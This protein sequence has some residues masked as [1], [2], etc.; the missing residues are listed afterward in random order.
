MRA[1]VSEWG[2]SECGSSCHISPYI[3]IC[4]SRD[5]L[6][7]VPRRTCRDTRAKWRFENS[8]VKCRCRSF[9]TTYHVI[10]PSLIMLFWLNANMLRYTAASRSAVRRKCEHLIDTHFSARQRSYGNITS[11][12]S[13]ARS[14]GMFFF[15]GW[16]HWQHSQGRRGVLGSQPGDSKNEAVDISCVDPYPWKLSREE[17]VRPSPGDC[18][19]LR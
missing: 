2:V 4:I 8:R 13:P 14:G 17:I 18:T 12:S 9:Q 16:C 15:L 11:T 3:S 1:W 7:S 5:A 19:Q 6:M 10:S